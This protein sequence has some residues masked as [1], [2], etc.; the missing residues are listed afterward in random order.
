[1]WNVTILV[2]LVTVMF[3]GEYG[4][5]ISTSGSGQ[6][7]GGVRAEVTRLT[8]DSACVEAI[9]Q[10]DAEV[11]AQTDAEAIVQSGDED[12]AEVSVLGDRAVMVST[13]AQAENVVDSDSGV[14]AESDSDNAAQS[15]TDEQDDADSE[16]ENSNTAT[17]MNNS[18]KSMITGVI[19]FAIAA[20]AAIGM[21]I[22]ST[23]KNN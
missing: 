4:Q 14:Q 20:A 13:V 3:I 10:T 16:E 9:A 15:N 11:A 19:L 1:M 21:G 7:A 2:A 5:M 23:R 8:E 12:W 6:D 18:S 17:V 22:I